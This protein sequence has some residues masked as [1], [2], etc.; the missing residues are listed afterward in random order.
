MGSP[1]AVGPS[2][3]HG[4][5]AR[6]LA[7]RRDKNILGQLNGSHFGGQLCLRGAR[8]GRA[9]VQGP[10]V[11]PPHHVRHSDEDYLWGFV[12]RVNGG[13]TTFCCNGRTCSAVLR[14]RRSS[15]SLDRWKVTSP[16]GGP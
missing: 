10:S 8:P 4:T 11:S 9:A 13:N 14:G 6:R 15:G 7:L 2:L 1:A 12:P 5:H 16:S 3:R